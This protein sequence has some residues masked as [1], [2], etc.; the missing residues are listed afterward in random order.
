MSE[1]APVLGGTFP[2][3]SEMG[4]EPRDELRAW[5]RSI[6]EDEFD[7]SNNPK[8]WYIEEVA[9]IKI[10]AEAGGITDGTSYF[11]LDSG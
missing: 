6:W 3:F 10:G 2:D 4:Y 11:A 7:E 5:T 9:G 1:T 8:W